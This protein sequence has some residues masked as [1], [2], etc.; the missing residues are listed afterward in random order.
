MKTKRVE[1]H[2]VTYL[3]NTHK[4]LIEECKKV[5]PDSA[6]PYPVNG[7]RTVGTNRN[8]RNCI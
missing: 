4:Y 3:V 5:Q 2:I 8:K 1:L 6:Q 7:Q